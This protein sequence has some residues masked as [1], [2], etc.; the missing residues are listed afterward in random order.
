MRVGAGPLAMPSILYNETY[1]PAQFRLG[2][3]GTVVPELPQHNTHLQVGPGARPA[4]LGGRAAWYC[5]FDHSEND[6][7]NPKAAASRLVEDWKDQLDARNHAVQHSGAG[8]PSALARNLILDIDVYL[9][10]SIWESGV[11]EQF[12]GFVEE[13][14]KLVLDHLKMPKARYAKDR[15]ELHSLRDAPPCQACFLCVDDLDVSS[16]LLLTGVLADFVRTVKYARIK[17]LVRMVKSVRTA[18]LGPRKEM[19]GLLDS[20]LRSHGDWLT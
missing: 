18:K 15:F 16:V 1:L 12:E 9:P 19:V 14:K 5:A 2:P 11:R 6:L 3:R 17:K 8:M 10:D 20:I 13:G 7:I 4:L